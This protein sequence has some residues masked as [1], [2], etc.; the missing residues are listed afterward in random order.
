MANRVVTVLFLVALAGCGDDP[1]GDPTEPIAVDVQA[2]PDVIMRV[3]EEPILSIGLT[4]GP[5]EYLFDDIQGAVRLGD[6]SVVVAVRGMHE[7]RRFGP[8]GQHQW[9]QGREGEGPGEYR[10]VRLLPG[11]TN[12]D[13]VFAYDFRN[14][15]VT[16][17]NGQG[18]LI[19]DNLIMW[20]QRPILQIRCSPGGRLVVSDWRD[21]HPPDPGPYRWKN[22]LGFTDGRD[23]EIEV[24]REGIPGEDRVAYMQAG[25]PPISGPRTWGHEVEFSATD[26]G[27]WMGTGDGYEI[28]FIDWKGITT[29]RIQWQG[30]D[31]AVTPDHIAAYRD[32]RRKQFDNPSD[33]NWRPRFEGWWAV[34]RETLPSI[35][36]SISRMLAQDDGGVWIQ[37]YRRPGDERREW[38]VFDADGTWIRTLDLPASLL[39]VDG[40]S[41]WVLAQT[42]DDVGV[43]R[44]VV[45]KLVEGDG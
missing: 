10:G 33:P 28:E 8:D 34:E 40:G 13:L 43:Q 29:R 42:R 23:S 39:V 20:K 35:F 4:Q 38:L 1:P 44:L 30:R 11:C 2:R 24:L 7:I 25:A 45:H 37:H 12:D 16:V 32:A 15:R 17:L 5:D 19:R 41:D 31:L 36:P 14:D 6:G 21:P 27:V 22:S 26:A 3:A 18:K 9:T